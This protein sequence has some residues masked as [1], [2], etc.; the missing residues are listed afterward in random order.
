MQN[1]DDVPSIEVDLK[2]HPTAQQLADTC[3]AFF[4]EVEDLYVSPI[5]RFFSLSI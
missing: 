5:N 1:V 2:A 4:A 3:R